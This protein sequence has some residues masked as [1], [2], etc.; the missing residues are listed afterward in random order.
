MTDKCTMCAYG[1]GGSQEHEAPDVCALRR[2]DVVL[3]CVA[4][5]DDGGSKDGEEKQ[6]G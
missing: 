1:Q 6:D 2:A 4:F 5:V 3:A